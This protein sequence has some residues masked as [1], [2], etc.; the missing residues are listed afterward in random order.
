MTN[1][2]GRLIKVLTLTGMLALCLLL[3]GCVVPPDDIGTNGNYVV[4][5]NNLPFQSLGPTITNTPYVPPA[6]SKPT[7]T[8]TRNPYANQSTATPTVNPSAI[9]VNNNIASITPQIIVTTF[10]AAPSNSA[11]TTL[12]H[13]SSGTEVREMQNRLKELGYLK[14]SADGDFGDATET[15]VKAFQAQ[16]GLTVD[17]K[18][19]AAT[20]TKLYSSS[21]KRAAS[22]TNTNTPKPTATPFT[23]YKNGDSGSEI[24][25]MQ[26]RLKELGYLHGSADGDFGDATEAAVRYFQERNGLS[27]DGKA[28]TYTLDKLYSSSAKR[29]FATPTP[30][31]KPTATPKA[32]NLNYY[33]ERGNSGTKVRTLQERLIALG[34]LEGTADASYGNATEYAVKAF[35]KRYTSLEDDGIAGPDTLKQLYSA[36]AAKA[37]TP[38]AT[39]GISL[40]RGDENDAV[41]ALQARLKELGFFTDNVIGRYGPATETAVTDFQ[42]ANGLT[43][44]GQAT[45][46]TLNKLFSS[47]AKNVSFLTEEEEELK[48]TYNYYLRNGNSGTKVRSLQERLIALGW[49]EGAADGSYGNATEYAVKAFQAKY[50]DLWTDGVAGPD[51]LVLLY[52]ANAVKSSTP[53]ASV[54]VTMERNDENDA[55]KA[56]QNRL[57]ELGFFTSTSNGRF[58]PATEA[59]VIA[60]QTANG[61]TA[62]GKAT[63]TTLNKLYSASAKDADDL[64]DSENA[65]EEE[66]DL[67][68]ENADDIEV[69]GYTTLRR[70]DKGEA[71]KQLQQT[72]KNRGF[73]SNSV[74]GNYGT[75][76]EAAVKAFQKKYGLKQDGVAGPATQTLLFGSSASS[77]D[78]ATSLKKGSSGTAVRNLQ[79]VLYELGYY[80]GKING[81]YGDTTADAVRAFQINNDLSPVDGVAGK[82]TLKVIYSGNAIGASTI[83]G[84]YATLSKGDKGNDVVELQE[85]LYKLG[86][87]SNVTGEYDNA[88][89]EAVKNLQRR[90]GLTVNGKADQKLQRLIYFGEPTPAW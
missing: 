47:S 18:A 90:N 14:G 43:A 76:T 56:M 51:T 21:A 66:D 63:A 80:D 4:S 17:G 27:V 38:V 59:A 67:T 42:K 13:G 74:T 7:A 89:V 1:S 28:G 41:K 83:T 64:K 81:E 49:L 85:T 29:A 53:A 19:G 30:T 36:G 5:D 45:T 73:F 35:Q 60:F 2:K 3:T 52:G 79:Y 54:G 25:R 40:E 15:A 48:E 16:N 44:T 55:V 82:N 75:A 31:A 9:G 8:P 37:S 39:L 86:Y 11:S 87:L 20:L 57:K 78:T 84:N 71:V 62:S 70:G 77:A 23:S 69:N 72:L 32:E 46:G 26:Q 22:T 88:T 6:T 10:T 58:G 50:K 24:R 34:W 68:P 65:K 61:I 33:L 12:K